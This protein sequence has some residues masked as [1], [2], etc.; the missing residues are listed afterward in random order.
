[1]K[2]DPKPRL[3]SR[4][5]AAEYR[6]IHGLGPVASVKSATQAPAGGAAPGKPAGKAKA[7][8]RA[9]PIDQQEHAIQVRVV[10][11]LR[12]ALPPAIAWSAFPNGGFRHP[13]TAR[14]LAEEG[15]VSGPLDLVFVVPSSVV[16]HGFTGWIEMKTIYGVMSD[17]QKDWAA[18]VDQTRDGRWALARSV[19]DVERILIGWGITLRVHTSADVAISQGGV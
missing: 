17:T 8:S 5:T 13:R 10:T 4:L 1:M 19:E 3:P 16:A 12:E 2:V 7:K 6:A 15:V 11:F 14:T 9:L 18:T